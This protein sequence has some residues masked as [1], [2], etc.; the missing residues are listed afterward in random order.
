MINLNKTP[1]A[2]AEIFDK[3]VEVEGSIEHVMLDDILMRVETNQVDFNNGDKTISHYVYLTKAS[4]PLM[5]DD[6]ARGTKYS[7]IMQHVRNKDGFAAIPIQ[8]MIKMIKEG[9]YVIE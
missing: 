8:E 5:Y 9:K 4:C 7:D 6:V 3:I 2:L 1:D